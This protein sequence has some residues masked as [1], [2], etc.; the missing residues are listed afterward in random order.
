MLRARKYCQGSRACFEEDDTLFKKNTGIAKP[1]E[2]P[3]RP[4]RTKADDTRFE[5]PN[6]VMNSYFSSNN[7]GFSAANRLQKTLNTDKTEN[8]DSTFVQGSA[9]ATGYI[10]KS[11]SKLEANTGSMDRL[12]RLKAE[13]IRDSN[14]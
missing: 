11:Q 6:S 1:R 9:W 13:A 3:R 4:N 5:Y 7:M 10:N 2:A 12:A 8:P 14:N